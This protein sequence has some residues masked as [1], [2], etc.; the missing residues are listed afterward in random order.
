MWDLKK[1]KNADEKEN[2]EKKN[3]EIHPI[4]FKGQM[5]SLN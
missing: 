5:K 3:Q 1:K 4:W 2:E